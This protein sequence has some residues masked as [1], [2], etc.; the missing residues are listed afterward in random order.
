MDE[1][2]P[3]DSNEE[4]ALSAQNA[5]AEDDRSPISTPEAL[6][7][8]A[9]CLGVDLLEIV[10]NVADFLVSLADWAVAILFVILF[11]L[12]GGWSGR[13]LKKWIGSTIAEQ[14]P[15]ISVLPIRTVIMIWI[16]WVWN[17]EVDI[18][19]QKK[20]DKTTEWLVKTERV[21]E[22]YLGRFG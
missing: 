8:I 14:I 5:E 16:I 9:I 18:K 1:P 3:E 6:F 19:L 21:V 12:K 4:E 17:N 11:A 10:F 13:W 15:L 20:V 7:A 22:K 2:Q